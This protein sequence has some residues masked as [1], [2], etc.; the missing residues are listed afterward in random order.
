[1]KR[2]TTTAI[3]MRSFEKGN[4]NFSRIKLDCTLISGAE[5]PDCDFS[6]SSFRHT[7]IVN[8]DF[9]GSDF[10]KC[11]FYGA[12]FKDVKFDGCDRD[13]CNYENQVRK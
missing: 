9:T 3:L 2:K 1:M 4:K 7:T 8:C 6:W 13:L 5:L 11:D 12:K 10:F